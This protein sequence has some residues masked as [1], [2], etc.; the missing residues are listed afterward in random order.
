MEILI[1]TSALA[2]GIAGGMYIASQIEKRVVKNIQKGDR[3]PAGPMGVEGPRGLTGP[4]G[5][6]GPIGER[7]ERGPKGDTGRPGQDATASN[8]SIQSIN[9]RIDKIDDALY[10]LNKHI[11]TIL[12]SRPKDKDYETD[13]PE[14]E[15]LEKN[16]L[17]GGVRNWK[18]IE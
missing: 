9:K 15:N 14:D 12:D 10:E 18:R 16:R 17:G 11:G 7:G 3:G 5:E 4:K 2:V 6:R 1:F 13:P 8:T